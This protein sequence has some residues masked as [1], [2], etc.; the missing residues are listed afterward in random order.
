M[1]IDIRLAECLKKINPSTT[2]V[3]TA[4]TKKLKSEGVDVVN[5]A[6]GEPDFDT[7]DFVKEQAVEAIKSGFT[8]YTPT[9]G[10]R[11]LKIAIA[12]KFKRDNSLDYSP[13]QIV[14]SSGAK[15]C[16]F[17]TLFV[18]TNKGDEVLIPSPYWVSYPEMVKLCQGTP[19]F[20]PA[21]PENDFKITIK[22]LEKYITSKTKA[23][24]LN[25]PSN[26]AGSVYTKDELMQI[27]KICLKD[28]IFVISDEVYEKIIF[29]NLEHISIAS[30][31]KEI[32][33][34]TITINGVSKSHSMTGW[35]IGYLAGPLDVVDAISKL[36]DHSTSNPSSISQKAALAALKAGEN[37]S[38]QMCA[39]FERRRDY[40]IERLSKIEKIKPVIPHGAFYIFCAISK[41]KLDSLTFSNRLLD[42][43]LVAVI[44]GEGFGRNDY[45]RLSFATNLE[46]LGK[47]MDRIEEW[48]GKL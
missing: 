48:L 9:S 34:L 25:S 37:F 19:R 29:D 33:D 14:V 46:E 40:V 32:F 21:L 31:G 44:P 20:I 45:I 28:K 41:T 2:L 26:P 38:Q 1:K 35:R 39:E 30:L 24:I 3:I 4:K 42:E 8:K 47:G 11:E 12:E 18:L 15:H 23:L 16:I 7:P 10:I 27:S 22:A 17:N 5:L 13:E 36:Q 6:A 43:A